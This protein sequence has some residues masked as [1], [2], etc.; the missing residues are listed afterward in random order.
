MSKLIA[1]EVLAVHGRAVG[2]KR[3]PVQGE[4]ADYVQRG[5]A[6]ARKAGYGQLLVEAE[7]GT[8]KT[9]GYLVPA[10][11]DCARNNARAIV[12]T[13]TV[14]LQRQILRFDPSGRLVPECDMA[15]ALAIVKAATGKQLTAGLRLGMRNFLDTD[16]ALKAIERLL[17]KRGLKRDVREAAAAFA[18]WARLNPGAQIQRFLEEE[19]LAALPGGLIFE[20]VC[21]TGDSLKGEVSY[22]K[23]LE[24]VAGSKRADILVTNHAML[25]MNSVRGRNRLL[26]A[27]GDEREVAALI[28]DECDRLER[29]A[30]SATSDLVPILSIASALADWSQDHPGK[31]VKAAQKAVESLRAHMI[32][33]RTEEDDAREETVQFWDEL[34]PHVRRG[35]F[36]QLTAVREAMAPFLDLKDTDERLDTIQSYAK[37]FGELIKR[38]G[39]TTAEGTG[40]GIVALRW[41]PT[42]HYPSIRT[43]RLRPARLLKRMWDV[44]VE[45]K[46]EKTKKDA[47]KNKAKEREKEEVLD[48]DPFRAKAL[49]LTSATIGTPSENGRVNFT[50]MN[51]VYGLFGNRN[52]CHAMNASGE[53]VFAPKKFGAARFVFAHPGAPAVYLDKPDGHDEADGPEEGACELNPKWVDYTVKAIRAAHTRGGRILVLANSYRASEAICVALRKGK[54][55]IEPIEKTRGANQEMCIRAFVADANG[56][57]VSPG[58]WE[59]FDISQRIGADGKKLGNAI[60]HVVI[61]QVPYTAP[62]GSFGKA[63]KRYLRQRLF[64]DS[65][66]NGL[67]FEQLSAEAVR[68]FKQGFGRGIRGAADSFTLWLTDP[69]FPRSELADTLPNPHQ[70]TQKVENRFRLAIPKRFRRSVDEDSPWDCGEV[71]MLDGTVLDPEALGEKADAA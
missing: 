9:L 15:R 30:H 59:G 34:E 63:L 41:S 19:G 28:V 64:S 24:H 44:W 6:A 42:R 18:D 50:E 31:Q 3:N 45:Q 58:A 10:G 70:V 53:G 67:V 36:N 48:T 46:N 22:L 8:G 37:R 43:F 61:T 11:L 13:H 54:H 65:E 40:Q 57:F 56:V 1:S 14:A 47:A 12:A 62:D 29:S 33:L 2:L 35:L 4:Y 25:M 5:L 49:V 16:R 69:R 52:A 38:I 23:Y 39:D 26:H 71:L 21:I 51:L 7:T 32:E 55:P 20:D 66:A 68:K 60:K 27:E 17:G